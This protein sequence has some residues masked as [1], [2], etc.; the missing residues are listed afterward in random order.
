MIYGKYLRVAMAMPKLQIGDITSNLNEII[1][2]IEMAEKEQAGMLILPPAAL[3][4]RHIGELAYHT[5]FYSKQLKALDKIGKATKNKKLSVILPCYLLF[6]GKR[7]IGNLCMFD[8]EI[9]EFNCLDKD[10]E[11]FPAVHIGEN[12]VLAWNEGYTLNEGEASIEFIAGNDAKASLAICVDDTLNYVGKS[13]IRRNKFKAMTAQNEN[14]VA[15][16]S[17]GMYETVQ[18]NLFSGDMF[19]CERGE[20]VAEGKSYAYD[21]QMIFAD[22]NLNRSLETKEICERDRPFVLEDLAMLDVEKLKYR[23]YAKNPFLPLNEIE[24]KKQT[25]QI[26]EMQAA[27]LARR[28]AHV[29]ADKVVIGVSGGLDSTL[30]LIA[31]VNAM[32][33]IGKKASDVIAITM[34]GLGTSNKTKGFADTLM[35]SLGVSMREIPINDAVIQHFNDI[36]HDEK[37]I[38]ATYENAQARERTQILMDVANDVNGIVVG[39]GDMSELALGWCTYNG[40]QMSMYSVNAGIP[41]TVI[42]EVIRDFAG[43]VSDNKLAE[44]LIGI[45]NLPI[46]PELIPAEKAG[47]IAQLT[48]AAIGPYEL[49]DFFLYHTLKNL[50]HPKELVHIANMTFENYTEEEIRRYLKIFYSRLSSQQFKRN[51]M[52]DGLSVFGI[53]L[54]PSIGFSMPSDFTMKEWLLELE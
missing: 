43:E 15:Y 14:S 45:L 38:N 1:K 26:L 51:S 21:G 25:S 40:D 5:F 34:P 39:T 37:V 42:R 16:I 32:K 11:N 3:T 53:S 6:R 36:G 17:C 2:Y 46:S 41:K 29:N 30:A 9:G 19:I 24:K 23:K 35:T 20:I 10:V 48:E 49:H 33:K 47:E 52:P 54:S 22:I 31:S 13:E 27:A 4:G 8:G 12:L 18:N 7:R 44:A 50:A 28:L